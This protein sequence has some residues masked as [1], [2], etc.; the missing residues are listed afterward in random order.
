MPGLS[1]SL[2]APVWLLDLE[3]GGAIYRYATAAT[4]IGGYRYSPGLSALSMGSTRTLGS[5]T[6]DVT[7]S[8]P[9]DWS[10]IEARGIPLADRKVTIR[11]LH[12]GDVWEQ[13]RI[14]LVGY[15]QGVEYG[16]L[17]EPLSF[18]ASEEVE[19]R[20]WMLPNDQAIVSDETWP[21]RGGYDI[22]D[23]AEGKA[24]PI[25]IGYPG[26]HPKAGALVDIAEPAY[27][28]PWVEQDTATKTNERWLVALGTIAAAQITVHSVNSSQ[29]YIDAADLSV[30]TQVDGLGVTVSYIQ[31]SHIDDYGEYWGGFRRA[32]GY[33]GG[34]VSPYTGQTLNGAGE[35]I[36]FLLGYFTDLRIDHGRMEANRAWLDRFKVDGVMGLNGAERVTDWLQREVLDHLPVLAVDG[37]NGLYYAPLRW[38][39]EAHH[40]VARLNLDAGHASIVG[41]IKRWSEDVFNKFTAKYRPRKGKDYVSTRILTS[42]EGRLDYSSLT[43]SAYPPLSTLLPWMASGDPDTRISGDSLC[44]ASQARFGVLEWSRDLS[45]CWHDDTANLILYYAAARWAWPKRTL[46]VQGGWHLA[47]LEPGDVVTVTRAADYL[48]DMPAIVIE[49]TAS[50]TGIVLDLVLLD[51]PDRARQTV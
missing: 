8:A 5:R 42:L 24:Y 1:A 38:D 4:E 35:V 33:G 25:P 7:I 23:G 21:V 2:A 32:S 19:R 45:S 17:G 11:L 16:P 22:G 14:Y 47:P 31:N 12:P 49:R 37:P 39:A 36:R 44:R 3:V 51:R 48:S 27:E 15:T 30:S 10:L 43:G 6:V 46:Q 50:A 13:S 41:G 18:T 20:A 28:L 34:V 40:A 26:D 9:V 29:N